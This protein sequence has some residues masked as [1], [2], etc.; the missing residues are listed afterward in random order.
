MW[1]TA[2]CLLRSGDGP[3]ALRHRAASAVRAMAMA[4]RPARSPIYP[5]LM[6]GGQGIVREVA[7]R[8]GGTFESGQVDGVYRA[9]VI[10]KQD[11][12]AQDGGDGGWSR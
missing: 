6:A 1:R 7:R 4:V 12:A 9:R 3:Q 5:C 11:R 8:H 2:T 10:L